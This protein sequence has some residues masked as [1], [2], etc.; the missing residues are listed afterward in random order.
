MQTLNSML[1]WLAAALLVMAVALAGC[2]KPA[3][4][5]QYQLHGQITGLDAEG[6]IATIKHDAI[7][8]FMGAMT[9]GYQVKD[10][11]EFSKLRSGDTINATIFVKDDDMWVGNIQKAAK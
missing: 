3:P 2:A 6:H 1:N 10:P 7:Q 11:T 5:K 9:M 4:A 8:G